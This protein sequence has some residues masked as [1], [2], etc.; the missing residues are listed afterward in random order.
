[1][2]IPAVLVVLLAADAYVVPAADVLDRPGAFAE[3]RLLDPTAALLGVVRASNHHQLT[4]RHA[5][6]LRLGDGAVLEV[7]GRRR[8]LHRRTRGATNAPFAAVVARTRAALEGDLDGL[9]VRA[10]DGQVAGQQ[11]QDRGQAAK[12]EASLHPGYFS[13]GSAAV[14]ANRSGARS[15]GLGQQSG[16]LERHARK[17][18]PS[19]APSR[20]QTSGFPEAS[21]PSPGWGPRC[22]GISASANGSML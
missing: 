17:M 20:E 6:E 12:Q 2:T 15:L 5:L 19:R 9:G 10:A 16:P 14:N 7:A 1:M 21:G 4:P 18:R 3:R 13:P 8:L 22:F 11:R